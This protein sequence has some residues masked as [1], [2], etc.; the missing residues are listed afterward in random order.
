[1]YVTAAQDDRAAACANRAAGSQPRVVVSLPIQNQVGKASN[2]I[3]AALSKDEQAGRK[4]LE[5]EVSKWPH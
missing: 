4:E 2:Q 5:K 3:E 1:M